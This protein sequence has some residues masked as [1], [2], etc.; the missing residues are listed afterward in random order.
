MSLTFNLL[1]EQL[2][3]LGYGLRKNDATNYDIYSLSEAESV[4]NLAGISLATLVLEIEQIKRNK[5]HFSENEAAQ[6][7]YKWCVF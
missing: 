5:A 6:K 7:A 2:A 3:G 1:A 4:N